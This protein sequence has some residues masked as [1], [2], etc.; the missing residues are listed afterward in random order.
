VYDGNRGE[1]VLVWWEAGSA[2]PTNGIHSQRLSWE[3]ERLGSEHMLSSVGT[4]STHPQLAFSPAADTYLVV[5]HTWCESCGTSVQADVWGT[6]Y[7]P[8]R[9]SVWLPLFATDVPATER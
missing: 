5:W 9:Y 4:D 8:Q 6:V 2:T 7:R 3:G 1:S